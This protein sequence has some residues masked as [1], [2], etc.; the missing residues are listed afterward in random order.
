MALEKWNPL[1]ELES[2][3]R[4]MDRI[5]EDLFP[6]RRAEPARWK[7]S[8]K[9]AATPAIDII[10]K[11]NEVVVRAEM[12]GVKKEDIDISFQDNALTVKGEIK[13]DD[14][15]KDENYAYSERNYRYYARSISIPFKVNPDRIKASLKDGL[16]TIQFPKAEELQPKKISVEVA[17]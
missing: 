15:V 13:E 2:M 3:R 4:E 5:W 6:A 16:L 1:R 11:N 8:E 9:G 10:D 14:G 12:P 17:Q 7:P